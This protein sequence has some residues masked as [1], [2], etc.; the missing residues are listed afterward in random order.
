MNTYSTFEEKNK[1]VDVICQHKT[2]GRIIPI[3]IRIKDD[4]GEYQTYSVK[5]YRDM[6]RYTPYVSDDCVSSANHV[7]MFECKIVIFDFEKRIRLLYNAY[8]NRWILNIG[9]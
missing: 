3:K 5:A 7:W 6:T 2:D 9:E 8:D 4:D 1:Y